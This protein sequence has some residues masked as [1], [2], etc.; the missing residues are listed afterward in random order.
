M[1]CVCVRTHR[2]KGEVPGCFFTKEGEC[3]WNRSVKNL[4][5]YH[6]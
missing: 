5:K 3:T 6:R 1:C 4:G 2:D